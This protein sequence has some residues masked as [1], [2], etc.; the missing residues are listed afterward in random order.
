MDKMATRE[1][2]RVPAVNEEGAIVGE[3]LLK[4]IT[5]KFVEAL[6]ER[7]VF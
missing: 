3:V 1:V 2:R 6:K 5:G 7:N 4:D